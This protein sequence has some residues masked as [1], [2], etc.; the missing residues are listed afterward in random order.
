M[1]DVDALARRQVLKDSRFKVAD[2]FAIFNAITPEL[3]RWRGIAIHHRGE[4]VILDGIGFTAIGR[5]H[6][7]QL[8]QKQV[9]DEG[10]SV[11]FNHP[12]KFLAWHFA[13]ASPFVYTSTYPGESREAM[14][15]MGEFSIYLNGTQRF[16]PRTATYFNSMQPYTYAPAASQ[17]CAGLYL[18]SFSRDLTADM[19]HVDSTMNFSRVDSAVAQFTTKAANVAGFSDVLDTR[20]QVPTAAQ[21]LNEIVF[22][23]ENV[24]V[25]VVKSGMFGLSYAN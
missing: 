11:S 17:P 5:L 2:P 9:H 7:L 1:R 13:N 3:E 18:Y 15:P 19:D 8:L 4:R 12:V 22:Y 23:C 21:N 24:N 14:S 20:V 25:L 16:Q 10:I 6:L